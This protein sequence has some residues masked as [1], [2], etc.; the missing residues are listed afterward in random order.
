M[1]QYQ[2]AAAISAIAD[3]LTNGATAN[4]SVYWGLPY[5]GCNRFDRFL[6]RLSIGSLEFIL[7]RLVGVSS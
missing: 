7:D 5:P 3:R 1:D 4:P 6:G 2:K